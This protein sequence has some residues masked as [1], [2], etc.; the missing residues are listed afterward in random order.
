MKHEEK[1]KEIEKLKKQF[2]DNERYE[3]KGKIYH[4]FVIGKIEVPNELKGKYITI[5]YDEN[6]V[7]YAVVSI[8]EGVSKE[9]RERRKAVTA[10]KFAEK[11]KVRDRID[12][13]QKL[14]RDLKIKEEYNKLG[15]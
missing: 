15:Y 4:R 12:R 9:E 13:E 11:K 3:N 14:E 8:Y 2:S 5:K 1:M 7:P 6:N 10:K